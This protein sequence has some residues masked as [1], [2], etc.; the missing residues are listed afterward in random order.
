MIKL[1]N[2]HI[3]FNFRVKNQ[4]VIAFVLG[5]LLSLIM[6]FLGPFGTYDF[7]SSYKHLILAGF[8]IVFSIFYLVNSRIESLWFSTRNYKWTVTDEIFAFIALVLITS[9]PIHFY[10]QIFLNDWFNQN[11]SYNNYVKHGI[12]FFRET[13]IPI[14]LLILPFFLYLR[15]RLGKVH[16]EGKTT[17]I[18]IFG[19]NKGEKLVL[20]KNQILFVKS[21]E[22]YV[23]IFY[24]VENDIK[25]TIFRNK[26]SSIK[27]QASFLSYCHRSYL[28]NTSNIKRIKGNS[29]N[30][31]IQFH[32]NLEIPLSNTYYK[33]VKSALP[34]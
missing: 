16:S 4:L 31:K 9:I 7:Q 15:N 13:L 6:I 22:N 19:V 12:W 27:E 20:Q 32:L 2:K 28:V 26:L 14:M 25:H 24:E 3:P 1:L 29:Q 23:E 30:A 33:K 11:E 21:S 34:L 10:N 17:E 8:G 18:E 5:C